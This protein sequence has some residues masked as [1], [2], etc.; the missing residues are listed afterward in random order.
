MMF[1]IYNNV[2]VSP[3]C[4]HFVDSCTQPPKTNQMHLV[5]FFA[6]GK[7]WDEIFG[8]TTPFRPIV[9]IYGPR[10]LTCLRLGQEKN[11][12]VRLDQEKNTYV[13]LDQEK[14]T[15]VRSVQEK[16]LCQIGSVDALSFMWLGNCVH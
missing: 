3:V 1:K 12:Y 13:R 5:I 4:N 14:N 15:C 2:F 10:D 16:Y 8:T 11:T 7:Y 6:V 9:F